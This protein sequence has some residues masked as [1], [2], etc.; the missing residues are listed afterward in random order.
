[1]ILYWIW[2]CFLLDHLCKVYPIRLANEDGIYQMEDQDF[3]ARRGENTLSRMPNT[4]NKEVPE[5]GDAGRTL[6]ANRPIASK[7]TFREQR[8]NH[9]GFIAAETKQR[10]HRP[11][12]KGLLFTKHFRYCT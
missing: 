4:W 12:V 8:L 6:A 9:G 7:F 2:P 3:L 10:L 5:A 1:M 11:V